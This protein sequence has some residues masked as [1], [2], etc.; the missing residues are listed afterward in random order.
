M[1]TSNPEVLKKYLDLEQPEDVVFCTYVFVDGTME[2][3]R[4]KTRVLDYEPTKV[5]GELAHSPIT[6]FSTMNLRLCGAFNL[7]R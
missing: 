2:N 7:E 3:V 5:E 4:A 6:E 1:A